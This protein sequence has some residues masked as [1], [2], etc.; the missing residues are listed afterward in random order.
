MRANQFWVTLSSGRGPHFL[1]L[2]YA[3]DAYP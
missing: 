1:F 3:G 2:L